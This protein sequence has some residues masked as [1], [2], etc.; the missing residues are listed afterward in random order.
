MTSTSPA[1]EM[2]LVGY[3]VIAPGSAAD[4]VVLDS[5]LEVVATWIGGRVVPRV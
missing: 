4:L 1:R 3:G 5:R 2:G